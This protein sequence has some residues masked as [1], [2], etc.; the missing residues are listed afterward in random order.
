MECSMSILAI[1]AQVQASEFTLY[2]GL[3]FNIYYPSGWLVNQ[4]GTVKQGTVTFQE[5]RNDTQPAAWVWVTW[6][7]GENMSMDTT[8]W[9]AGEG[10]VA[11][12]M[13]ND[14]YYLLGQP[15]M[16]IDSNNGKH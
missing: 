4:T 15:A 1:P 13:N 5:V 2:N 9:E 3:L 10:F 11:T 16:V 7:S 14:S 8:A 6:N 12:M